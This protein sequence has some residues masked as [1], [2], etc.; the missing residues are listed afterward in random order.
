LCP[1]KILL[2]QLKRI[3]D[4]ILTL[5]AIDALRDKFPDAGLTLV[6]A[7]QCAELL[8]AI[9][10]VDRALVT[11]RN[12][13]D[14]GVFFAVARQKFDYC[15]DFTQNDRSAILTFLSRAEK[16]IGAA[17][18]KLHSKDRAR[19]YNQFAQLRL[20]ELHTIDYNLALLEPL[21][22][23]DGSRAVR[24]QLPQAAHTKAKELLR[25]EKIE[26]DFVVFHP[27]SA[28]AEKFWE[29]QRWAEVIDHARTQW[30]VDAVITGSNWRFEQEHVRQIKSHLRSSVDSL[31]PESSPVRA[32]RPSR[33]TPVGSIVDLSG[34]TDL[35]TL[36]ALI[37][38]ARLLVTV[39]SAAMHL[40][41]TQQAPQVILF[42]PTNPFHW[43]PRESPAVILQ[44][45][46][47][48]AVTDFVPKQARSPM[49]QISTEAVINAMDSL[50]SPARARHT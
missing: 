37:S 15:I 8:P 40:A 9:P 4:L 48:V 10:S 30:R 43:R 38:E 31:S 16:R 41:A 1:V 50:L 45:E 13:R 3:G 29:P 5:P 21:R 26:N 22:I 23:A 49:K 44:G 35:L 33:S 18:V 25:S 12:L 42:G 28:R 11:R 36:A 2:L 14:I 7:G 46:S 6:V 20:K 19:V 32:A 34:K 17:R 24:L 39:D 27:G 47:Q